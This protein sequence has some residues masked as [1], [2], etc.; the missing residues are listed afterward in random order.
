MTAGVPHIFTG[1][2]IATLLWYI[3]GQP[4][5]VIGYFLLCPAWVGSGGLVGAGI[6]LPFRHARVGAITGAGIQLITLYF[7]LQ[8]YH[9]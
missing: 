8:R 5:A 1:A 2:L 3:A 6:L 9:G 7:L 4:R